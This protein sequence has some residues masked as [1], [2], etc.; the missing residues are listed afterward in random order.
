MSSQ[1]GGGA[2]KAT[3]VVPTTCKVCRELTKSLSHI[4]HLIEH[5]SLNRAGVRV[6]LVVD[7]DSLVAMKSSG[8]HKPPL[9]SHSKMAPRTLE[10]RL[11]TPLILF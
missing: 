5:L 7:S 10:K 2:G 3:G 9:T 4:E 11:G 8:G 1:G 6:G